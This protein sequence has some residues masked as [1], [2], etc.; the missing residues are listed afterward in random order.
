MNP[1]L[2]LQPEGKNEYALL[3]FPGTTETIVSRQDEILGKIESYGVNRKVFAGYTDVG[4]SH[5]FDSSIE[6]LQNIA[7][8]PVDGERRRCS[9]FLT[10][11][12][13]QS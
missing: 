6:G 5:S 7:S 2:R 3:K 8:W 10:R 4:Q 13:K 1:I 9:S 12:A 11:A